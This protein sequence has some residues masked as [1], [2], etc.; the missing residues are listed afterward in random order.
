MRLPAQRSALERAASIPFDR[1]AKVRTPRLAWLAGLTDDLFSLF[2]QGISV[3]DLVLILGG[4]FLL[5]KGTM[6]V[7]DLVVGEAEEEDIDTKPMNSFW[8]VI[9]QIAVIDIVFSL[10]SVIAAVGMANQKIIMVLAILLAVGVMLLAWPR[11]PGALARRR[12]TDLRDRLAVALA[13]Y[14]GRARVSWLGLP[15]TAAL[16]RAAE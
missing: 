13:R 1:R 9:A 8:M 12:A 7:R 14:A 2:G 3:R 16:E 15:G 5:V 6:E 11:E 4:V 10:D